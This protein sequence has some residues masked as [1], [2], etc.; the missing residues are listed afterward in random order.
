M[1]LKT[2]CEIKSLKNQENNNN[3]KNKNKKNNNL[4]KYIQHMTNISKG[5][6]KNKIVNK[7]IKNNKRSLK[8][9]KTSRVHLTFFSFMSII[10]RRCLQKSLK[11]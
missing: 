7:T 8:K 11:I 5:I 1:L 2:N 9:A 6:E 3:N 4:Q 10:S